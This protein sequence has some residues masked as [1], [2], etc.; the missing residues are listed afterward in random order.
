VEAVGFPVQNVSPAINTGPT[1]AD[2]ESNPSV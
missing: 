1:D 2:K